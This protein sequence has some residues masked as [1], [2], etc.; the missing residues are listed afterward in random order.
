[1]PGTCGIGIGPNSMIPPWTVQPV[2]NGGLH[3]RNLECSRINREFGELFVM[4]PVLYLHLSRGR[5]FLDRARF[6]V[7]GLGWRRFDD[8][9]NPGERHTPQAG[10]LTRMSVSGSIS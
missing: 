5:H 6:Y 10:V 8:L 3:F 1:M 2:T 9:F 4:S 7:Y